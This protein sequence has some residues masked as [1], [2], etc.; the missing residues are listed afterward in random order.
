MLG[1]RNLC[2]LVRPPI[3]TGAVEEGAHVTFDALEGRTDGLI[4]LPAGGEGA[5]ARLLA[6]GQAP[7]RGRLSRQA[8]SRCFR[9]V[10]MSN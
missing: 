6:E 3:S 9:P 4:A 1:Y 10:S 5:L 7:G 8:S 2:A